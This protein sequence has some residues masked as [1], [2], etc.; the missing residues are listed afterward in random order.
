VDIETFDFESHI[1]PDMRAVLNNKSSPDYT[2]D[3]LWRLIQAWYDNAEHWDN[4]T[5]G[6]CAYE[7]SA[8]IGPLA[9]AARPD[10]DGTFSC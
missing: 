8:L 7:L 5:L 4:K 2:H 3:D 9:Y 6:Q 10:Q 1:G